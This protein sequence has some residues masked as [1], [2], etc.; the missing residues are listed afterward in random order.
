MPI[1]SFEMFTGRK[2]LIVT[3]H[4]KE[5]VIAPVLESA[6]GVECFTSN[7]FDTDEL[8]TFTGEI[9]RKSDSITT[10]R[11]KCILAMEL[12][13]C[14]LAIASEG[15]FGAHPQIPFIPADDE[16]VLL[17]DKKNNLEFIEREL[18]TDTNFNGAE[19]QNKDELI[20]FAN[21]VKF[22]SHALILKKSKDDFTEMQKGITDWDSLLNAFQFILQENNAAFVETDMRAM[23]NPTRMNVI[24][25]A[26]EK[27]VNKINSL[28]PKCSTPGFSITKSRGGL[29][30]SLCSFPTRSTL[31]YI[32]SCQRCDFIQEKM[33]PHGKTTEEPT[34]CDFCNP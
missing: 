24:K 20:S 5:K 9:E 11:D 18:S 27:L 12:T 15:S 2:L 28:C 13:G 7:L 30:C 34:Y 32:Y 4:N 25:K 22:P 14:D 16:L 26:V 8:G 10:V 1:H 19:I 31:S 17:L 29:L 21:S 33:Y 3:K 23:F 6:L